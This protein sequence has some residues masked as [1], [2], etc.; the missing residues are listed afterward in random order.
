MICTPA[1][2]TKIGNDAHSWISEALC[3]SQMDNWMATPWNKV[4]LEIS[5]ADRR[6]RPQQKKELIDVA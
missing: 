2:N 3:I 6:I 4:F 5:K 1:F